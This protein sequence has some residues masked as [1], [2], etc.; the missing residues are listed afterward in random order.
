MERYRKERSICV[1]LKET[2]PGLTATRL[3]TA[4]A[5]LSFC[6]SENPA[7][8]EFGMIASIGLGICLLASLHLL[9]CIF[10]SRR[11]QKF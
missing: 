3:T 6:F 5:F 7:V 8:R 1:V 2:V 4:F 10:E 9:P 11:S